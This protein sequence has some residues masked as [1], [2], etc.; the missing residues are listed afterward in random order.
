MSTSSHDDQQI[1]SEEPS[2]P[3]SEYV[4]VNI[5]GKDKQRSDEAETILK[6]GH[7]FP[8]KL[9]DWSNIEVLHRNTLPPRASFFIYDDVKDA[10][11]RDVSK[12]R[13]L[14][15][16]GTWK[17]SLAKCPFDA[18]EGFQDPKY[19]TSGWDDIK[20]PGMWQLQ[21]HGKGPQYVLGS[22]RLERLLNNFRQVY[23]FLVPIP[24]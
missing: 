16:S 1:W 3:N 11:T 19:D 14:S 12:S 7:T 8:P 20:V 23:E 15:L 5:R 22:A 6:A 17:F 9:P 10:L 2:S 13:T 21:G 24:S 18:P 4:Q